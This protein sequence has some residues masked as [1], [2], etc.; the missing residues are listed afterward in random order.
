MKTSPAMALSVLSARYLS[1]F[2]LGKWNAWHVGEG[3]PFKKTKM[4]VILDE[5]K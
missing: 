3:H 2:L 5:V 1:K 4:R